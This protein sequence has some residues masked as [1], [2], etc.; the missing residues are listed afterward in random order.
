LAVIL[1]NTMTLAIQ[2]P[3]MT[4]S[5]EYTLECVNYIFVA[6]FIIEAIIKLLGFGFRYFKDNWNR[7]DF[8][9]ITISVVFIIA[10]KTAGI[11][12]GTIA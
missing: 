9:I 10:E 5:E 3:T 6:I 11:G 2:W 8:F 4:K 12:F 1:L 7:F